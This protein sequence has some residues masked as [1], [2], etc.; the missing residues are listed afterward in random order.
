MIDKGNVLII[1][2]GTP[3]AVANA[4]LS[5]V[6]MEAL[7]HESIEQIYGALGGLEGLVAE[8]L[9]DLAQEPQSNIRKLEYTPGMI[10]GCSEHSVTQGLGAALE[11]IKA[12]DIRYVFIIGDEKALQLTQTLS[13]VAKHEHY[14]LSAIAVLQSHTNRFV[15][16]DHTPG[17]AST[18]KAV[19]AQI[20]AIGLEAQGSGHPSLAICALE[21]DVHG[22]LTAAAALA[23]A[24]SS[25]I[26]CLPHS[27]ME[28]TLLLDHIRK[29][30]QKSGHA[31][32]V[33]GA[34]LVDA[35]GNYVARSHH[36]ELPTPAQYIQ[37]LLH[38]A[39][40]A[41]KLSS[42][43]LTLSSRMAAFVGSAVDCQEA[44]LCA[45]QAVLGALGGVGNKAIVLVRSEGGAS[46][47]TFTDIPML[48]EKPKVLPPNWIYEGGSGVNQHFVRYITPLL[49][50]EMPVT[51]ANGVP[52]FSHLQKIPVK[53]LVAHAS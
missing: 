5:G 51:F 6:I 20:M 53:R 25:P 17:Y 38:G 16:A 31:Q 23:T 46:E 44:T 30:L 48:L 50:G 52:S 42:H 14:A 2:E 11:V 28:A 27:P 15:F 21:D 4:A 34:G 3:T 32:V 8:K 47:T 37:T 24:P 26:L 36:A 33:V 12:H 18:A 39:F 40:P 13:E 45:A 7:N 41:L 49:H 10:L 1:Q 43:N 29:A 19:A 22:W 9:I 35:D